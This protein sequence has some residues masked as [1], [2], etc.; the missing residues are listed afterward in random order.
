LRPLTSSAH[1]RLST[2]LIRLEISASCA[3]WIACAGCRERP[4]PALRELAEARKLTDELLVHQSR[5]S[6]ATDRAVLA[7]TD[8][9]SSE[10]ASEARA[11]E[12]RVSV[13]LDQLQH[14]VEDLDYSDELALVGEFRG[15]LT[16]C[17]STNE[18]TLSLAVENTNARAQ[19]LAFGPGLDAAND[20][21]RA[22]SSALGAGDPKLRPQRR[23]L[24]DRAML[25][26][27]EVQ[28]L[29]APHIVA[30][31]E[32]LMSQYKRD[33]AVSAQKT[34]QALEELE[35]QLD[36]A[37]RSAVLEPARQ[38]LSQFYAIH[39]KV[40]TLSHLNTDARSLALALGEQRKANAMCQSKLQAVADELTQHSFPATR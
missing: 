15:A 8:N 22:L 1:A 7:D 5:A 29:E 25:G 4:T 13:G 39:T 36:P 2:R 26:L 30:S 32:A 9:L 11:E 24:V 3:L 33:M 35:L 23:A 10:F 28:V 31:D 12:K 38:A 21:E 40:L 16:K 27:R 6:E 14:L 37:Q 17:E 20:V 34:N 19:R 18:E